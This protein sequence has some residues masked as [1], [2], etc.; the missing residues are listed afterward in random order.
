MDYVLLD[1]GFFVL[2]VGLCLGLAAWWLHLQYSRW[3]EQNTVV[4]ISVRD[5]MHGASATDRREQY[6]Q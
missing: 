6:A 3:H 2:V 4:A 5:H 1:M